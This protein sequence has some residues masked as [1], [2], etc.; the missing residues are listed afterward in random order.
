MRRAVFSAPPPPPQ[1]EGWE[2]YNLPP[3]SAERKLFGLYQSAEQHTHKTRLPWRAIGTIAVCIGVAAAG[4][5][6]GLGAYSR[7]TGAGDFAQQQMGIDTQ[8]SAPMYEEP[9]AATGEGAP[10][11]VPVPPAAA[12]AL[13][14]LEYHGWT[15]YKGRVD[16][17]LCQPNAAPVTSGLT[18]TQP[19]PSGPGCA[20]E[21]VWSQVVYHRT[22]GSSVVIMAGPQG[23]DLYRITD[24]SF[25][26][27]VAALSTAPN[28]VTAAL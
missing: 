9:A 27:D 5:A 6:Y 4:L 15:R 14:V 20:V 19:E 18:Q 26:L 16:F 2:V 7:F 11:S 21:L 23:P 1:P 8:K 24:P 25:L 17:L 10:A 3:W 28:A 22:E 12:P 13:P